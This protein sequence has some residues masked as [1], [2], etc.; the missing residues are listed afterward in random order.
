MVAM[1]RSIAGLGL[2]GKPRGRFPICCPHVLMSLLVAGVP[3][4]E[5][6]FRY[7][8]LPNGAAV[9]YGSGGDGI[10]RA[11]VRFSPGGGSLIAYPEIE[12]VPP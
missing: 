12:K 9:E 10:E 8:S 7:N 5:H 11:V 1:A 3:P 6:P 4:K 2:I